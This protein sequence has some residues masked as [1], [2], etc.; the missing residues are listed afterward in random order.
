MSVDE[1]AVEIGHRIANQRRA[2][3]LSQDEL[4]SLVGIDR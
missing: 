4:A 1:I 3:S 2:S